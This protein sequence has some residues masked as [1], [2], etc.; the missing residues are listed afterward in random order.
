M[1]ARLIVRH[2][3]IPIWGLPA[4][5]NGVRVAHVS[6]LHF[7]NWSRLHARA[8][9][10]LAE[11]PY[12]LL[13]VTGDFSDEPSD[14]RETAEWCRRFFAPLR[15]PLG[16]YAVL[17]NHDDPRLG[18]VTDLPFTWLHDRSTV[19]RHADCRLT[20]A[21]VQQ[22]IT[23]HGSLARA[24]EDLDGQQAAILLAHYPSTIYGVAPGRVQ[25]V[26]SGHTHGGQ[27]RVP[28]LGALWTNDRLPRALARGLHLVNR[29]WLHVNPG[30]GVAG[31]LHLRFWCPPEITVL[32][33]CAVAPSQ[34]DDAGTTQRR[35]ATAG[36][37]GRRLARAAADARLCGVGQAESRPAAVDR[38]LS[39]E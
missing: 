6:D 10:L 28:L 29:T 25:L 1:E 19:V 11:L 30:I 36:I 8:Q 15:P 16:T 34:M 3:R 7:Q 14:W 27:I 33:L 38:S 4:E 21:G 12:D 5:L 20:L 32:E 37:E 13:A 9:R 24:M 31:P 22:D 17:G 18:S 23:G 2:Q 39:Q 26:L 35:G